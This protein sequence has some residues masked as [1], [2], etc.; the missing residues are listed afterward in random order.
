MKTKWKALSRE[1]GF[2]LNKMVR[3]KYVANVEVDDE[4]DQTG[5]QVMIPMF[6][7]C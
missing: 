2:E 4:V 6:D 7:I 5:N 1:C 3:F